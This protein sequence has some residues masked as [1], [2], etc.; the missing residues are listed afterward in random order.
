MSRVLITFVGSHDKK[1]N[2]GPIEQLLRYIKPSKI[3]VFTTK[4]FYT[5]FCDDRMENYYKNI[6]DCEIEIIK[7]DI[8]NPTDAEEI[9]N[10]VSEK[11]AEINSYILENKYQGFLNL[12]SGTPTILSV[13]SLFAITGQ[14]NR[15]MG[16]YAPNPKFDNKI[17]QNSL[18][19]YKNSFAYKTIKDLI[20]THNYIGVEEFLKKNKILPKLSENIAFKELVSFAKNRAICNY[21]EA[22][23]IY[24]ESEY[25]KKYEYNVPKNLYEKAVECLMSAKIAE[26]NKDYFQATL[27]LGIIR[28]NLVSF[29]LREILKEEEMDIIEIKK[30]EK[31]K[32]E[33][34]VA[35]LRGDE[36]REKYPEILE[37]LKKKM[38][39][40]N[41]E[42]KEIDLNR[43]MNSFVE[44]LL[45]EY[46]IKEDKDLGKIQT[47]LYSLE[48]LKSQRNTIA[49]T[50]NFPIYKEQWAK[51]I[52]K[53]IIYISEYLEVEKPNLNKY[54]EINEDLLFLLKKSIN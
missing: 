3:Y 50:I 13:L 34:C 14:L 18:D 5:S 1:D 46:F 52:E 41:G 8:E 39:K 29:L 30:I 17:K 45:L 27:K 26:I 54:K 37:F 25:L 35:F 53:I 28:E 36:I 20:N 43:E 16:L 51:N 38:T 31:R 40:E 10:K 6:I 33:D 19:Y 9:S 24:E 49:H 23:K 32:K 12:T 21:E 11:I 2:N 47:E 4:D 22:H 15:T 44:G 7:T 42:T 48:Q